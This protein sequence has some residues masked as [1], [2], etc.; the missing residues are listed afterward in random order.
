MLGK[1]GNFT[2]NET[3]GLILAIGIVVLALILLNAFLN[4]NF[5]RNE[6]SAESYFDSFKDEMVIVDDGGVGRF[7]IWQDVGAEG[8]A[9]LYLVYFGDGTTVGNTKKFISLGRNENNICVCYFGDDEDTGICNWCEDL[10][11]PVSFGGDFSPKVYS[12]ADK[13]VI[14]FV[15]DH[16]EFVS[17]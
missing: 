5:D 14:N 9:E 8:D 17:E 7:S 2:V 12:R 15:E 13:L 1:K 6:K 16:Y 11:Y 3:L 4:P 10:E